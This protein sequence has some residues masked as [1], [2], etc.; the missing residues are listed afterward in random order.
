[1]ANGDDA[2]KALADQLELLLGE[3]GQDTITPSAVDTTTTKR[4]NYARSYAALAPLLPR[5]FVQID[6]QTA[7]GTTTHLWVSLEDSTGFTLNVRSSTTSL[8]QVRWHTRLFL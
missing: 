6:A 8:K 3:F 4:V 7:S 2:I 5:T 1:M